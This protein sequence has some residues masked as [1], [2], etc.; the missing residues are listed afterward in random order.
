M[1]QHLAPRTRARIRPIIYQSELQPWE[2]GLIL[3]G[4]I[5]FALLGGAA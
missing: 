2:A 3:L 5:V 4:I 1:T